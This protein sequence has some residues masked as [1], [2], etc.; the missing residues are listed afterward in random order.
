MGGE[1][2]VSRSRQG[3]SFSFSVTGQAKINMTQHS[4]PF[5]TLQAHLKCL[6]LLLLIRDFAEQSVLTVDVNRNSSR[7]RN[8][9][10]H[11]H[12]T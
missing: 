9:N 3:T 1:H 11:F 7:S 6:D 5:T 10:M 8:L 4:I 12:K 2:Q